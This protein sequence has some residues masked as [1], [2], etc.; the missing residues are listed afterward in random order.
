MAHAARL[1]HRAHI[2]DLRRGQVR[3]GCP[4][5]SETWRFFDEEG[6]KHIAM[7]IAGRAQRRRRLAKGCSGHAG[8]KRCRASLA[9]AVQNCPWF[10]VL[11]SAVQAFEVF[12]IPE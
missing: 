6:L 3:R 5:A 11:T 4:E 12:P 8:T 1:R 7:S 10:R 2:E 9:T